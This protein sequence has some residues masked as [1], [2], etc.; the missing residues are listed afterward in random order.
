MDFRVS[1]ER[2][3]ALTQITE[4]DV[5]VEL[6]L[7][8]RLSERQAGRQAAGDR[9]QCALRARMSDAPGALGLELA[10]SSRCGRPSIHNSILRAAPAAQSELHANP[11]RISD[12]TH[13]EGNPL[14]EQAAPSAHESAN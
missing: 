2:E 14:E 1:A 6:R 7:R 5:R 8:L 9:C 10:L 3:A 4:T 12:S 11:W 13:S